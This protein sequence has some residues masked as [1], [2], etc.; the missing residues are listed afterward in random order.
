MAAGLTWSSSRNALPLWSSGSPLLRG[1]LGKGEL[2]ERA[3]ALR[4]SLDGTDPAAFARAVESE[5]A[6]RL[7]A[8]AD[9]IEAYR[10]HPYRRDLADPPVLWQEGSCR[11]LDYGAGAARAGGSEEHTSELQSLMRISYAVFCF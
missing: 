8:L 1:T 7:A 9:G 4:Q 10:R 6:G 3:A 11:L 5:V 2:A